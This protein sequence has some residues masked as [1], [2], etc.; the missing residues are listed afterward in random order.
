[1]NAGYRKYL[2]F[3]FGDQGALFEKTAPWTPAKTFDCVPL[4]NFVAKKTFRRCI[5]KKTA[6]SCGT[7]WG[8]VHYRRPD[9]LFGVANN[10]SRFVAVGHGLVL[11]SDDGLN[12]TEGTPPR[13]SCQFAVTHGK[14]K[15]VAVGSRNHIATSPDGIKWNKRRFIKGTGELWG[16][17]HGSGTFVVVGDKGQ[18]LTSPNAIKWTDRNPPTSKR[19][20]AVTYGDGKF[21]AVGIGGVIYLSTDQG[22]SWS[23]EKVDTRKGMMSVTYGNGRFVAGGRDGIVYT[24]DDGGTWTKRNPEVTTFFRGLTYS[25]SSGFVAVG[26][27]RTGVCMIMTSPDG[28][29]WTWR[30][31]HVTSEFMDVSANNNM[32]AAVALSFISVSMCNPPDRGQLVLASPNGGEEWSVGEKQKIRWGSFGTVGN[33]KLEYSADNGDSWDTIAASIAKDG[34]YPWAIPPRTST[35]CL[36]RVSEAGNGDVS[37]TSNAAFIIVGAAKNTITLK[38]P[39]DGENWTAGSKQ[40]I[41]WTG[42]TSF[43]KIDLEYFDGADWNVIVTGTDDVGTY[44]WTVPDISTS[45]AKISI[46]GYDG[47]TNPTDY[48]DKT[49]TIV[50][51]NKIILTAPNGGETLTAGDNYSIKWEGSVPFSKIDIEYFDGNKWNVIVTGA[52]DDG[53]YNWTVPGISTTKAKIWI[54]GYDGGTNPTDYSDDT[55][56]ISLL[57]VNGSIEVTSPNGGEVWTRDSTENITWTLPY[58]IEDNCLVKISAVSNSQVSDVSNG[59]FSISRDE[60]PIGSFDTPEDGATGVSGSIAV[61]GWALDD[62][63]VESVK[64]Y[65]EVNED[66]LFI[67]DAIFV[68]G[69]RPDVEQAYPDYPN[70]YRAG[71]GFML[72]TNL[73]PDGKLVLKAIAKNTT[74]HHVVLGNKTI[75]VDNANAVKPFGVIDTPSRGGKTSGSISRNRGWVLTPRPN[76][77]PENGTTIKVFIDGQPVGK[78]NYNKYRKDIAQIFPGYANSNGAGVFFDFDT[79]VYSSGIHTI[80][81]S[82]TDN[83]GNTAVIGPRYFTIRNT[84]N[85]SKISSQG[86]QHIED[87]GG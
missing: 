1:L 70:S 80:S 85:A 64:I 30:D 24:S 49:F 41:T 21:V 73:F 20:Q 56:T 78:A 12:W 68:E 86:T 2:S 65:R 34:S 29:N 52:L 54:K 66:F 31:S 13:R 61:T 69:T 53:I 5:M 33:V 63:G 50:K 75:F 44:E 58:I 51:I 36:V 26:T 39:N 25:S 9:T 60:K 40:K 15:F 79:T 62:T 42:S 3:A 18:V 82:V 48:S 32:V 43:S 45:E 83:A 55:F 87:N 35:Q 84:G 71:W 16:V 37:D 6:S 76:K 27:R 74:G 81:W 22:A 47:D 7:E 10:G 38:S 46:K 77:I 17:A 19:L 4:C 57:P 11:V 8:V 59:V 14:G 72:L 67:G 28:V 23:K